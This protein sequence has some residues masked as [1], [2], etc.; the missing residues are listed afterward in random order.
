MNKTKTIII[1]LGRKDSGKG[2]TSTLLLQN[3]T[4]LGISCTEMALAKHLKKTLATLFEWD[5]NML[6]GSTKESRKWREEVDEEWSNLLGTTIIPRNMMV[7]FGS[8]MV[9]GHISN[10]FWLVFLERK[11][12]QSKEDVII[13]TD[14]RCIVEYEFFLKKFQNVVIISIESDRAVAPY[15]DILSSFF[16]MKRKQMLFSFQQ[17]MSGEKAKDYLPQESVIESYLKELG[18][19]TKNEAEI[20]EWETVLLQI[21]N[22]KY[23]TAT[24]LGRSPFGPNQKAVFITNNGTEQDLSDHVERIVPLVQKVMS[25]KIQ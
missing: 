6:E 4:K 17:A 1:L 14:G 23:L 15:K 25:I 3:L 5:E 18:V 16:E 12:L 10:N 11:I 13:I 8:T 19:F 2:T 24:S 20:S 22:L 9:R 7:R 21:S